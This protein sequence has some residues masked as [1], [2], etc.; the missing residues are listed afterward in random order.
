MPPL[1]FG[2]QKHILSFSSKTCGLCQ[3][4]C[5]IYENCRFSWTLLGQVQSIS[6]CETHSLWKSFSYGKIYLCKWLLLMSSWI[7]SLQCYSTC[8]CM[9][10]AFKQGVIKRTINIKWKSL[11]FCQQAFQ[12]D[13]FV[14]SQNEHIGTYIHTKREIH[15]ALTS[16]QSS[17]YFL[18][19]SLYKVSVLLFSTLWYILYKPPLQ[20]YGGSMHKS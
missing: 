8:V 16:N 7:L 6:S 14:G 20:H 11:F 15:K 18:E 10:M 12:N 3:M 4:V 5:K 9:M 13:A 1:L 19:S 17:L 2:T